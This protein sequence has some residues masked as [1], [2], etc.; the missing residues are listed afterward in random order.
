M[1]NKETITKER[2]A[3]MICG[4]PYR[5]CEPCEEAGYVF[6]SGHGGSDILK[7]NGARVPHDSDYRLLA[8]P[9]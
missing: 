1:I 7:L 6:Y 9:L 3:Y 2:A 4:F 8:R 5:V